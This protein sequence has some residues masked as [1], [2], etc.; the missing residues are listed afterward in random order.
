MLLRQAACFGTGVVHPGDA[1]GNSPFW[2]G[3][4][5]VLEKVL[6]DVVAPQ[7][8]MEQGPKQPH[9][10]QEA[11]GSTRDTGMLSLPPVPVGLG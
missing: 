4:S 1:E 11:Q 8:L 10:P 3:A 7:F 6:S 9:P 5:P 2:E